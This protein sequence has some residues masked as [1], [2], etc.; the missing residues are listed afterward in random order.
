MRLD[1]IIWGDANQS[2]SIKVDIMGRV[3][4]RP[5]LGTTG[6]EGGMEFP[7]LWL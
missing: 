5:G 1:W 7:V 2:H 6:A 3:G 4:Q